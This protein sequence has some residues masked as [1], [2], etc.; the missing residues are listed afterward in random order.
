MKKLLII[1]IIF[2]LTF[3]A[4]EKEKEVEDPKSDCEINNYGWV[5]FQNNNEDPYKVNFNGAYYSNISAYS[6][7]TFKLNDGHYTY[8]IVQKSGYIFYPTVYEGAVNIVSCD[9]E[10]FIID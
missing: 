8:K 6:S 5:E 2:L 1:P 7:K 4:C 9:T 10:Y 3:A